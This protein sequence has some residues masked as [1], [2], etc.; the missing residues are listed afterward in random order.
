MTRFTDVLGRKS[1]KETSDV[2][3]KYG[4]LAVHGGKLDYGT[5]KIA[6]IV[7]DNTP[8]E[9]TSFY[10]LKS[11]AP[12][13]DRF[14]SGDVSYTKSKHLNNV[15]QNTKKQEGHMVSIHGFN[16]EK[17]K[18]KVFVGGRNE[19]EREACGQYLKKHLDKAGLEFE[20]VYDQDSLPKNL[21]GKGEKNIAN[22]AG[23]G[24][25]IELPMELRK[26]EN[27]QIM[28]NAI[29]DY[30]QSKYKKS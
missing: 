8:E 21:S 23:D 10:S 27:Q 11:T 18:Y 15:V 7:H 3:G 19:A 4:I 20:V 22:A 12:K 29:A 16:M 1:V 26:G 13:A 14:S 6:K 24:V 17:H 25:Q 5:D 2:K 9:A 28:G 30:I